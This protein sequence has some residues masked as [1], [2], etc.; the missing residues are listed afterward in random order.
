MGTAASLYDFT[1][2]TTEDRKA[3]IDRFEKAVEQGLEKGP[4]TKELVRN[5]IRRR[6]A[7][8]PVVR[9]KRLSLELILRYGRELGE[10]FLQYP[11]DTLFLVP[12]H[13]FIGYQAPD[14]SNAIDP[15]RAL[16]EDARWVDEW[17]VEWGHQVGGTGATP[18]KPVIQEPEQWDEYLARRFPAGMPERRLAS[19]E[20]AIRKFG[21]TK[22]CTGCLYSPF[23]DRLYF[24]RG[25]EELFVDLYSD[26]KHVREFLDRMLAFNLDLVRRWAALGV[27]L[28]AIFEDWGTQTALLISP[29]MWRKVFKSYY[30]RL[31]E[32]IHR[33]GMDTFM[34][35]CGNIIEIIPDLIECGLD[36]LD[37]IQPGPMDHA[38][39]ARRFGGA[40]A[41]SGTVDVQ[42]L[43][44][45]GTPEQIKD[46]IRGLRDTFARPFKNALL[47]SPAN[48]ITPEVPLENLRALFEA[49]HD[50]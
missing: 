10:L 23:F 12:Y 13:Y 15:M 4:A 25:M 26:E 38:E 41:F 37:P 40:I 31:F 36:I 30:R 50:A 45:F 46:N 16:I 32:E 6:G 11:D 20:P 5:V 39:I 14:Q 49:C 47:I 27:D 8:R 29:D 43:L 28:V 48:V 2:L 17:G 19:V 18:T 34:H 7:E 33:H 24:V 35:S 21:R 44:V 9:L 42:N 1:H 3:T 22:H